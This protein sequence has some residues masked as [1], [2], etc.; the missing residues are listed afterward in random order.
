MWRKNQSVFQDHLKYIHNEILKP[1]RVRIIRYAERVQ[2]MH[3]LAEYLPPPSMKGESFK[4]SN[5]K[6]SEK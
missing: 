6:V 5:W 2:E 4:A 1:F 3:D